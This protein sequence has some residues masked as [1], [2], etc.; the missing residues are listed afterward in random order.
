[1]LLNP[2]NHQLG[3]AKGDFF[4]LINVLS[5]TCGAIDL[6]YHHSAG[7]PCFIQ[8]LAQFV[9][10]PWREHWD[11][12]IPVLQYLKRSLDPG[13]FF[14]YNTDLTLQ[15]YYNSNWINCPVT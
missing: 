8:V 4:V 9:N 2:W 6:S 1:M 14:R 11:A 15:A 7:Y 13:L 12:T 3:K 5:W 10:K